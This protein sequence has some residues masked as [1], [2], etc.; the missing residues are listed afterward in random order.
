MLDTMTGHT[1]TPW[2]STLGGRLVVVDMR[3]PVEHPWLLVKTSW[4]PSSES[5]GLLCDDATLGRSWSRQGEP[6]PDQDNKTRAQVPARGENIALT[7]GYCCIDILELPSL[8]PRLRLGNLACVHSRKPFATISPDSAWL[9]V[10][11]DTRGTRNVTV[12]ACCDGRSVMSV[13]VDGTQVLMRWAPSGTSALL[14]ASQY[15]LSRPIRAASVV[16]LD[17]QSPQSILCSAPSALL[18][19]RK[20]HGQL[21]EPTSWP[22]AS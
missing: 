17:I 22:L 6:F 10:F 7:H 21:M 9:A 15:R 4:C 14:L 1:A 20:L 2:E 5:S 13:P 11:G 16:L 8:Q 18:L 19:S 12:Y 3:W